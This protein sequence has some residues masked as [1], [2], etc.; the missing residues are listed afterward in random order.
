MINLST[1][2]S[3]VLGIATESDARAIPRGLPALRYNTGTGVALLP[4]A[5]RWNNRIGNLRAAHGNRVSTVLGHTA[6][7]A[8]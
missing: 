5:V 8:Q 4:A 6:S 2:Y 7:S 3:I 1:G